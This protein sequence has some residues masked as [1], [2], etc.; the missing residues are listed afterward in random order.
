M[1]EVGSVTLSVFE[2]SGVFRA[3]YEIS[4]KKTKEHRQ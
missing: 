1:F 2:T 3:I 4:V